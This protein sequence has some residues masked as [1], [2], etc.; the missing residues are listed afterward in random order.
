MFFKLRKLQNQL[1]RSSSEE[2]FCKES[3]QSSYVKDFT[4]LHSR[5]VN[6]SPA[7]CFQLLYI[8]WLYM[9]WQLYWMVHISHN[10]FR[11]GLPPDHI[12][13]TV[14]LKSALTNVMLI[15]KQLICNRA[16]PWIFKVL[17][18]GIWREG[19]SS[20]PGEKNQNILVDHTCANTANRNN[21]KL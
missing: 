3:F 8:N 18:V 20:C 4:D 2:E 21:I 6:Y 11:I 12:Q 17:A 19:E 14:Y 10:N 15:L 5:Q 9:S 13:R 16:C 1:L 7:F